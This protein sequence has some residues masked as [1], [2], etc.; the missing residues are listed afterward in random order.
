V[1]VAP[2]KA[3]VFFYIKEELFSHELQLS[4]APYIVLTAP[5]RGFLS[6]NGNNTTAHQE[7]EKD[8][9]KEN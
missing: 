9:L 4:T 2:Q 6:S 8:Y 3:T 7:T 5:K 1:T